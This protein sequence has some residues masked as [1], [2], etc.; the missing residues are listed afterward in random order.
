MKDILSDALAQRE[1]TQ[2]TREEWLARLKPGDQVA[3]QTGRSGDYNLYNVIERTRYHIV[4]STGSKYKAT[5]GRYI[6][7]GKW[8]S[9]SIEEVTPQIL[10]AM[11]R[12]KLENDVWSAFCKLDNIN[13]VRKLSNERLEELLAVLSKHSEETV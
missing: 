10:T 9:N 4:L 11:K 2:H 6:N 13:V 1:G 7:A 8:D 12:R 5:N 3:I